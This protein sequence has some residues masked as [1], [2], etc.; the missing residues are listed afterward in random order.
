MSGNKTCISCEHYRCISM[1]DGDRPYGTSHICKRTSSVEKY[2][3][4]EYDPHKNVG[5]II[6]CDQERRD[7]ATWVT[8]GSQGAYWELKK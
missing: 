6:Y 5:V 1:Y 8:C 2:I 3:F 7:Q 4:G